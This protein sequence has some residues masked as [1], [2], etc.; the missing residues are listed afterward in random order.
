MTDSDGNDVLFV[1][2]DTV[3]KD[4]LT[5]YDEER[6]TTPRLA[7]FAAEAAVFDGAVAPAPWTLPVHAS[8][9]T[10]LYPSEHEATQEDPY[11]EGVT[12]LAEIGRAHV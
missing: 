1:V 3:R 5:V 8:L 6:E 4:R 7:E 10:G 11:L 9:F 12:T 2:L